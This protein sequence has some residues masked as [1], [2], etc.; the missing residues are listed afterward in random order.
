MIAVEGNPPEDITG[1]RR[2]VFVM[3]D[4]KVFKAPAR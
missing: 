1:L 4:G 2:V 3:K